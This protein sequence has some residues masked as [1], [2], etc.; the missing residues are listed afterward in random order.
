VM[1][2]VKTGSGRV[3]LVPSVTSKDSLTSLEEREMADGTAWRARSTN[4]FAPSMHLMLRGVL[5]DLKRS[6]W[7]TMLFP[8]ALPRTEEVELTGGRREMRWVAT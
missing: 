6:S 7:S 3:S 8:H 4:A 2:C 5:G 1:L